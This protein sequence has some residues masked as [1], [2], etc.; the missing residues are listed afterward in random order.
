MNSRHFVLITD[1]SCLNH[2]ITRKQGY[3]FLVHSLINS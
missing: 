2:L 1:D 3:L